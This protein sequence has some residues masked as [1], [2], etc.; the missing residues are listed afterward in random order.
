MTG[1]GPH[2]S[3]R[4]RIVMRGAQTA[5]RRKLAIPIEYGAASPVVLA[6]A[7]LYS[8]GNKTCYQR[9]FHG[10]LS[11]FFIPPEEGTSGAQC[12]GMRPQVRCG[13][14]DVASASLLET[15]LL[16]RV[17]DVLLRKGG[18]PL[19]GLGHSVVTD[20]WSTL[21]PPE[22]DTYNTEKK[23]KVRPGLPRDPREHHHH[24]NPQTHRGQSLPLMSRIIGDRWLFRLLTRTHQSAV[25]IAS[26]L[27]I[28]VHEA[29]PE[30]MVCVELKRAPAPLQQPFELGSSRRIAETNVVIFAPK[31]AL[32]R[33][34]HERH[35]RQSLV[36]PCI[37]VA[38]SLNADNHSCSSS[39][40][41]SSSSTSSSSSS[42]S[43]S[44]RHRHVQARVRADHERLWTR[45]ESADNDVDCMAHGKKRPT[46]VA[47]D[48]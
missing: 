28:S 36:P 9:T 11:R 32:R 43:S 35:V 25:H 29:V 38:T 24:H 27:C 2:P 33:L 4:A 23:G 1:R 8:P 42:S 10:Y 15:D 46:G 31:V 45:H 40:S 44:S 6:D 5:T 20:W 34:W 21:F 16:W 26:P 18:D 39:S 48:G 14:D 22:T 19:Q 13:M 47:A 37:F 41:S 17:E 7:Y 3:F 12:H 30:P